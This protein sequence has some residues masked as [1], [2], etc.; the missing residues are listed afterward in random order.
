MLNFAILGAGSIAR[1]MA[2]T[3]NKM[4]SSG[5]NIVKLAAVASR[6]LD[7]SKQFSSEFNIEKAYGSYDELYNDPSIDLVYI[8]T[9]HNFHYEQCKSCLQH[10]KNVLCEKPFT[11]T[12]IK[13]NNELY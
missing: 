12:L 8:A 9:P 10:K 5:K 3:I 11:V 13:I 7:K 1:V 4:N 2:T 6:T